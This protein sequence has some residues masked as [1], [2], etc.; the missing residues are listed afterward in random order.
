MRLVNTRFGFAALAALCTVLSG[1][2]LLRGQTPQAPPSNGPAG[3]ASDPEPVARIVRLDA[4]VTDKQGRPIPNLDAS[5]FEVVE[6][7]VAQKLHAVEHARPDRV[8][9]LLLDEFHVAAGANTTTVREAALR[10][11]DEQLR[12]SDLLVVLRPLDPITSIQFSRDRD[13]ARRAIQSF[14]GRKGDFAALT[15]FEQKYIG[16]SPVAVRAARAQ[17]VVSAL[18]GLVTGL[19]E[20]RA[21]RSAIVLVTE[22][23]ARDSRIERERRVPEM[24]GLVRAASRHNVAI[25]TFDP[26]GPQSGIG[27]ED[28]TA[29]GEWAFLQTLA[30]ETGGDA[31]VGSANLAGAFQRVARDLDAYY[32]LTYTSSH[33]AEGQFYDVQ[34]RAKQPAAQVRTRRGY[35]APLR[36]ELFSGTET[37]RAAPPR[38]LKRSPLIDTWIGLTVTPDRTPQ[39]M[40]T[41]QPAALRTRP[42]P[43]SEPSV[44]AVRVTTREGAVLFD[45]EVRPPRATLGP[46]REEAAVFNADPGRIQIDLEILAAD[47]TSIDKAAHDIDV[48]DV[49]RADPLILPPQVFR[50]TS[51]REF[52]EVSA[53]P[54]A[55]P[56]PTRAFRRT[57]RLLLR[58]PTHSRS[59]GPITVGARVVN[60]F[61]QVLRDVPS[62]QSAPAGATQFDLPLGWLAP[63]DYT[64][65]LTAKNAAGSAR[66]VVR[67]RVTG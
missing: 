42:R 57:D 58:V 43:G 64:L 29:D 61:G 47:G 44:V 10:F 49:N 2:P 26:R 24:Q 21:G 12:P 15:E 59:G 66:E 67:F 6:G 8:V 33:S 63:G 40:L 38:L 54:A 51:A 41:W 3:A 18:R 7:G 55:A 53:D 35:W 19:G 30:A 32:L 22:G 11:V 56:V 27:A 65:E 34:V 48:P 36:V 23:F 5:D 37:S 16:R 39:V 4:V 17:I 46:V 28:R 9:A 60:R 13:T 20:L 52:R 14:N 50:C 1:V 31:V 62:M 45:G 25:Y